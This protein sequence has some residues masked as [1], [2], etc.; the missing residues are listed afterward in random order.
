MNKLLYILIGIPI[1]L[2]SSCENRDIEPIEISRFDLMVNE[3]DD[4]SIE[5][6]MQFRNSF[7]DVIAL[8][9]MVEKKN[10]EED[11]VLLAYSTS[12]SVKMFTPAVVQNIGSLDTIQNVL[13][14]VKNNLQKKLPTVSIG[15]IYSI[16]SSN[17]NTHVF[18]DDN[19]ML[20]ALNHYLGSGFPGYSNF[21]SYLR[22]FKTLRFLPYDITEA[23]IAYFYP[24]EQSA[25]GKVL[26]RLLYEG[27]LS[28]A[29]M[30]IVPN[31]L[32]EDVI[33]C[34]SEELLWMKENEKNIWN[35]LITK[36]LLYSTS[37]MDISRLVKKAPSVPVVHHDCP[38]R[39]GRYI[40]FR[41]VENYINHNKNVELQ[42]LLS[43][44]FYNSPQT[45]I[46]SKY[47][48]Q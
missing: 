16:I 29:L 26:N 32:L 45:L 17:V 22:R 3:Y 7:S 4:M 41:I 23:R 40:G 25:D 33:G 37:L 34:T 28:M 35:T 42:Y 31:V 5:Q 24:F 47:S 46:S 9:S 8:L 44:Q 6:Q 10:L 36:E 27:A 14:A 43:P 30:Q 2:F 13:G 1:I 21:D 12:R 11:S 20:V 15:D 19:T 39:V 38:G 18:M 48:P